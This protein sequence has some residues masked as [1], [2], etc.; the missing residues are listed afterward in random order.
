[1]ADGASKSVPTVRVWL[2]EL[3]VRRCLT[4]G[5]KQLSVL[6]NA[7][8]LSDR[9]IFLIRG[10]NND[11]NYFRRNKTRF[12]QKNV[13]ERFHYLLGA[14]CLPEDE[15]RTWVSA[16]RTNMVRPLDSLFCSWVLGKQGLIADVLLK[17]LELARD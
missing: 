8:T 1:L 14:T 13:F 4:I 3:Y 11:T 16:I 10:L 12:E 6:E 5:H 7:E 2:L 15:F 17:R 9:Q